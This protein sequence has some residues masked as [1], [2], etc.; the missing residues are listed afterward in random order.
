MWSLIEILLSFFFCT[1]EQSVTERWSE[2]EKK[3]VAEIKEKHF[4]GCWHF[5]TQIT[6]W[7]SYP[8]ISDLH[9]I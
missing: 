6:S 3:E 2:E 9:I 1:V 8:D 7:R 4:G 5:V